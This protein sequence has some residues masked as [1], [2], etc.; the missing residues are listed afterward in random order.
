MFG[1]A[2]EAMIPMIVTT[3]SNSMSEKPLLF[4]CFIFVP[5]AKIGSASSAP[6]RWALGLVSEEQP[7]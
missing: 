1:I 3:I 2:I 5:F 4:F 6:A 7:R